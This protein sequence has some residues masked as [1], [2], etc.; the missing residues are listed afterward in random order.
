MVRRICALNRSMQHFTEKE[1]W[2]GEQQKRKRLGLTRGELGNLWRRLG[3]PS[4]TQM[5]GGCSSAILPRLG[6]PN[7]NPGV[8]LDAFLKRLGWM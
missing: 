6:G 3:L 2:M 5:P 1:K 8:T 7:G 4:W